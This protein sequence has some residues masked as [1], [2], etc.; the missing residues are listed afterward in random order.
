MQLQRLN[1]WS[2]FQTL[3]FISLPALH[4]S[5]LTWNQAAQACEQQGLQLDDGRSSADNIMASIYN[6]MIHTGWH[7]FGHIYYMGFY[8]KVC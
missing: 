5:K 4:F 1:E 7:Q 3:N 6:D 8:A 2:I